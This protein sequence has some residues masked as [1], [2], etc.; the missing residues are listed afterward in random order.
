MNNNNYNIAFFGTPDLCIPILE[1]LQHSNF[2]P[3]L[4]ITN[5]DKP[6]GRKQILNPTP[7]S[8][9]ADKYVIDCLKP[10]KLTKEF[11]EEIQSK[12]WDLFIVVAYGKILPEVLINT[13]K[14]G[15]LNI[16]YSLLPR[17]RGAS[18]VES[19]IL[20]GDMITGVSI[21]KMV[22]ELDAGP[23]VAEA[24]IQLEGDEFHHDMKIAFSQI[25]ADLLIETIPL[26]MSGEIT[27]RVQDANHAT[28]CKKTKKEDALVDIKNDAPIMLWR[29]YRAY[30]G[31]PNI[32][33]KEDG[34]RVKITRAE[35]DADDKIF[36][37]TEVVKEGQ[38]KENVNIVVS[39]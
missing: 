1:A 33:F 22:Y 18:P 34:L 14:Y 12:D 4:I 29:K 15:T 17:W 19:T 30:F 31:W 37:I 8:D 32:Y 20:S 36:T 35:F 23:L 38:Q 28:F 3:N 39:K 21:Q 13:P 7:V 25:G 11:T 27:P 6:I 5:Q 10:E 16:H 24:K 9:F 26:F 2:A